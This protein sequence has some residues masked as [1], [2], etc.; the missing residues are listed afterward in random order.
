MRQGPELRPSSKQQ[1]ETLYTFTVKAAQQL[2]MVTRTGGAEGG[3]VLQSWR[4]ESSATS[5]PMGAKTI[6]SQWDTVSHN[7]AVHLWFDLTLS[8][9]QDNTFIRIPLKGGGN[10]IS[11]GAPK[12]CGNTLQQT[13][14]A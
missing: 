12:F 3:W 6:Q 13:P 5:S 14:A 4:S 1:S 8:V 7:M 9:D 11:S 2:S 10:F